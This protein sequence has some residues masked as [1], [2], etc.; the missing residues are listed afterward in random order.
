MIVASSN[1]LVCCHY[2]CIRIVISIIR[3]GTDYIPTNLSAGNPI[4][5][6]RYPARILPKFPVGVTNRTLSPILNE[7]EALAREK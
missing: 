3:K 7:A 1:L 6:A 2:R 4:L 5:V